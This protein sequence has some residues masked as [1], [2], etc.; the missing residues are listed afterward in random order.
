[1]RR[2]L[3][4]F[5]LLIFALSAL[6]SFCLAYPQNDNLGEIR[7]LSTKLTLG[8][9]ETADEEDLAMDLP[10]QSKEIVTSFVNL[11]HFRIHFFKD[12]FSFPF[13]IFISEQ[14]ISTLRC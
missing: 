4:K 3:K 5:R 8:S 1:V 14:K 2:K 9:F 10:T 6:M 13:Q 11:S 12:L 7:F